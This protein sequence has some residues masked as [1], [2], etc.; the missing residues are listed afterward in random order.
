MKGKLKTFRTNSQNQKILN[1]LMAGNSLTVEGARILGFGSNLRSR[2][3]N[4]KEAGYTIHT[5]QISFNGG[6]V[7]EYS[8]VKYIVVPKIISKD[9]FELFLINKNRIAF[10]EDQAWE[11]FLTPSLKKEGY[12]NDGFRAVEVTKEIL[13]ILEVF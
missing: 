10:T 4:L 11:K 13:D 12:E 6:Y 7:F 9:E 8:L 2:I 3:S 5:K 1:Y